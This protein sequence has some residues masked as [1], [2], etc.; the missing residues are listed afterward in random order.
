MGIKLSFFNKY[1][2]D[3]GGRTQSV[4]KNIGI[5]AVSK[6]LSVFISF[7]QIPLTLS[8]LKAE[9]YGVWLTIFSI[10]SWFI[11]FD[12]GFGNGL[13]NKLTT[14]LVQGDMEKA[15]TYVSTTYFSL[16]PVFGLIALVLS[17]VGF[18]VPWAKVLNAPEGLQ[19]DLIL[20]VYISFFGTI[21]NLIAALI[22]T[23]I[24]THQQIGRSN[25]LLLM[26]QVISLAGILCIKYF[27]V[28]NPFLWVAIV[29]AGVPALSNT[30]ISVWFY[31]NKYK[32][33]SPSLAYYDSAFRKDILSIGM[34][35]FIIQIAILIIFSTDNILIAQMYNPTE[36]TRYNIVYKYF[37]VIVYAY[38]IISAPLWTMYID[39]YTKNNLSWINNNIKRLL[40]LFVLFGVMIVVMILLSGI[41]FKL[42]I[43]ADFTVSYLILIFMGIYTL[44]TIWNTIFVI[45]LNSIGRLK[46]QVYTSVFAVLANIPLAFFFN[47]IFHNVISVIIANICCLLLSSIVSVQQYRQ[48]FVHPAQKLA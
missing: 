47:S 32:S 43:G 36:V 41:A 40:K 38:N 14:A 27:H 26:N 18:F 5:G 30:L 33:I 19:D 13:K 20:V 9:Y 42:W 29:F 6:G 45:P 7:L 39:A 10:S 35:F 2:T 23:V 24:A 44:Q 48:A 15:K 21:F 46:W 1:F 8:I 4:V 28:N 16:I 25:M 3:T 22:H 17:T 37:S 12:F 11:F 31:R 34:K